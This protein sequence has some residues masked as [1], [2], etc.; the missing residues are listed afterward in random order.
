[1]E[2]NPILIQ[3]FEDYKDSEKFTYQKNLTLILDELEGDFNQETINN[4]VLWKIN[5]YAQITDEAFELLN[6]IS[7]DSIILDTDKTEKVLESLLSIDGIQLPIASTILRF[8]NKNIYQIIDQRVFRMIYE[9]KEL[10]T[11][12]KSY[13][14]IKSKIDLYIKYLND[15]RNYCDLYNIKFSDSDRIIYLVDKIHNKDKRISGY[16]NNIKYKSF[17]I[18]DKGNSITEKDISKRQLRITVAFKEYFPNSNAILLFEFEGEIYELKFRY[19]EGKSYILKLSEKLMN[20]L[21]ISTD[22]KI[23]ITLLNDSQYRIKSI[24]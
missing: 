13:N 6:Q 20:K 3:L 5:R 11:E 4:I 12:L 23:K 18:P 24:I 22:S 14:P 8:K 15:L 7:S 10:N 21:R 2:K 16:G 19:R 17:I 1:M 9:G